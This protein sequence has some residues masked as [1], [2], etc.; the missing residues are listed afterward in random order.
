MTQNMEPSIFL[1]GNVSNLTVPVPVWSCYSAALQF[2]QA[3]ALARS[4]NSASSPLTWRHDFFAS[5]LPSDHSGWR[6]N[7]F[8][9][10]HSAWQ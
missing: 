4:T 8:G 6:L 10:N 9:R 5:L 3:S 7:P 2:G 1:G